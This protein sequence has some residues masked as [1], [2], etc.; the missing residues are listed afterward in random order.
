[1]AVMVP[2]VWPLVL[3]LRL[4]VICV[5][6]GIASFFL[7]TKPRCKERKALICVQ[8]FPPLLK[9]A[10]G[11]SKRYLTLCRALIDM[12]WKVSLMTPVDV[13]QSKE[14]EVDEW[15]KT[16]QLKHIPAR[17]VRM[18]STDGIAVFLDVFS[19]YNGGFLLRELIWT[20]G[21]D[22]LIA[23]DIPW[24]FAL[25]L[26]CRAAGVPSILTS[27]TDAT[28]LASFRGNLSLHVVWYFHMLSAQ[29]ADIHA[30]VSKTFG[31][32]LRQRERVTVEAV[33]PP[34][35]WSKS[36]RDAPATY[37]GEAR[38]LRKEWEAQLGF[39]PKTCFLYAGRWSSEK[40]IHKLFPTIPDDCALVV[41]GDGSSD[42]AEQIATSKLPRNVLLRRKMLGAEEL[43]L[44]YAAADV[45]VSASHFETLGN[46]LI[47]SWCAGTPPAVHPAQGHLEYCRDGANGFHVDYND[48]K[49]ARAKLELISRERLWTAD[50][51]PTLRE[52]GEFFRES[53]FPRMFMEAVVRPAVKLAEGRRGYVLETLNRGVTLAIWFALWPVFRF[54]LRSGFFIVSIFG[55]VKYEVLGKLGSSV[56]IKEEDNTS[57]KSHF[58]TAKALGWRHGRPLPAI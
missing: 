53:D 42:Y 58:Q 37:A 50:K 23:D 22:V 1:M 16:G 10:G 51:L 31:D 13:T 18:R 29:L 35:L 5:V 30:T 6:G 27:H 19:F 20:G 48:E 32:I 41:V 56:E 57:F 38:A 21:Y 9:S 39:K 14:P 43:R 44:A 24:R 4:S 11:V 40:R 8:A 28:Q 12:G 52:Q 26:I 54:S 3:F 33:W 36:F 15:L 34:I 47:E 17:G 2:D 25:V 7:S 55:P 45:F 46:T 49:K